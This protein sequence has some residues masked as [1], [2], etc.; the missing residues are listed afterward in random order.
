MTVNTNKPEPAKVRY[1]SDDKASGSEFARLYRESYE[2]VYNFVH[3]RVLDR[4]ATEDIVSDSYLKA[5]RAFSRFDSK[6]A[7]FSTWIIAIAR[8]CIADYYRKQSPTTDIDQVDPWRFSSE[9]EYPGID[10]DA[11]TVKRLLNSLSP[12][13]RELVFMKYYE[14]KRNKDIAAELSMNESTVATRLQRAL[15][16]MRATLEKEA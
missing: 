3:Y 9:D 13:D 5:A 6:R 2:L 8:N 1:L 4:H 14:D 11:E 12:D 15:I 16:K 10:D 7:K